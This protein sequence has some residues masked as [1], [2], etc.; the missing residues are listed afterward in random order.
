MARK[1][2]RTRKINALLR[3]IG[4]RMFDLQ[5]AE[6]DFKIVV[7]EILAFGQGDHKP[8]IQVAF[9]QAKLDELMAIESPQEEIERIKFEEK[10]GIHNGRGM[11]RELNGITGRKL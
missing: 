10:L 6:E 5:I 9:L 4:S 8:Q 11:G 7:D 3:K 1:S 2:D